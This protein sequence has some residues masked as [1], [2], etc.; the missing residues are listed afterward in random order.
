M[1]AEV[2]LVNGSKSRGSLQGLWIGP[3][4]GEVFAESDD[5]IL[6][7]IT[8]FCTNPETDNKRA[9]DY[10]ALRRRQYELQDIAAKLLPDER[11]ANCLRMSVTGEVDLIYDHDD[12]TGR[13]GNVIVCDSAW[14]CPV[15]AVRIG[16]ERRAEL[17]GALATAYA[18]GYTSIMV[19]FTLQ[20]HLGEAYKD[21]LGKLKKAFSAMRRSGAWKRFLSKYGFLGDIVALEPRISLVAGPH[22]HLHVIFV[23]SRALSAVEQAAIEDFVSV[24]YRQSLDKQGGYASWE[25][26][27]VFSWKKDDIDRYVS[28]WGLEGELSG[29]D[30]KKSLH[31]YSP[32]D[33][34]AMVGEGGDVG[35]L[36]GELFKEYAASIKGS[37]RLRFSD[38]LKEALLSKPEEKPEAQPE[39]KPEEE[40][41]AG[42]EVLET[43]E[44]AEW[45]IV[46]ERSARGRLVECLTNSGGDREKVWA[47]LVSLGIPRRFSED[48]IVWQIRKFLLVRKHYVGAQYQ[49]AAA[50]LQKLMPL[51]ER[52]LLDGIIWAALRG[53]DVVL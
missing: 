16:L 4:S 44:W 14:V 45:R 11:V 20:H 22:P 37:Q 5:G 7:N 39:E 29:G 13:L 8:K 35:K 24:H 12:H 18:K 28:K 21:V 40:D 27:V 10:G 48:W 42:P 25:R 49:E 41:V 3:D 2:G 33:L 19:T 30:Y 31:S 17:E 47:F 36:A 52:Y 46:D 51:A 1:S 50:R 53:E 43:L 6:G 32:F 23:F 15:C 38:G 34:L 9:V 26:G